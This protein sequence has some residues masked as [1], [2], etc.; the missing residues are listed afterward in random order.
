MK[1]ILM[2]LHNY[3]DVYG[4]MPPRV[5]KDARGQDLYSWR[6]ALL[7]FV[8][9][10]DVYQ[11]YDCRQPWDSIRNSGLGKTAPPVYCSPRAHG[12]PDATSYVAV[13]DPSGPWADEGP[14]LIPT[15]PDVVLVLQLPAWKLPWSAPYDP[16][17]E[18][19]ISSLLEQGSAGTG[20]VLLGT[21]S[22][23]VYSFTGLPSEEALRKLFRVEGG[24]TL[25]TLHRAGILGP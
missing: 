4:C 13:V 24:D 9:Y 12:A 25:R 2:A 23:V 15:D 1:I 8:G 20:D 7:P 6:V 16:G 22:G 14:R 10:Q 19:V 3:H 5:V 18:D 11:A 17:I 21:V